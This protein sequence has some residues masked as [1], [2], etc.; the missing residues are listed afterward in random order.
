MEELLP[1]VQ[2]RDLKYVPLERILLLVPWDA[3]IVLLD[4]IAHLDRLTPTEE[5]LQVVLVL[6]VAYALLDILALLHQLISMEELLPLVQDRDLKY[7]PLE[8]ILLLV[9]R[10]AQIAPLEHI[11]PLLARQARQ[12][13][14]HVLLVNTALHPALHSLHAPQHVLLGIHALLVRLTP[15]EEL[16]QAVL[17]QVV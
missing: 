2:D 15:T 6:V 13:A 16:L 9:P 14:H 3:Q 1:L 11:L 5:L 12:L 17:V 10:H 4:T 7:A 8:R